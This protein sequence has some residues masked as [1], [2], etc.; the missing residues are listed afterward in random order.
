MFSSTKYLFTFTVIIIERVIYTPCLLELLHSSKYSE[1]CTPNI[2]NYFVRIKNDLSV[3]SQ[4]WT[5]LVIFSLALFEIF[6]TNASCY[7]TLTPVT[8]YSSYLV[9]YSI[10]YQKSAFGQFSGNF[11]KDVTLHFLIPNKSVSLCVF[12]VYCP[13][14]CP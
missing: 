1:I 7:D 6:L 9:I 3:T 5:F 14:S 13:L 11:I 10:V 2:T 8:A 4:L 12:L